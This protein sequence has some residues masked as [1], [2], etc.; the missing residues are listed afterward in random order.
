MNIDIRNFFHEL[1]DLVN[2]Y[3]LPWEVRRIVVEN[4]LYMVEKKADEAIQLEA[5]E[6]EQCKNHIAE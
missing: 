3:D 5:Q 4:V 1:I 2:K 6:D